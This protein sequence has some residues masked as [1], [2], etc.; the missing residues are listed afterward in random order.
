MNTI[1]KDDPSPLFDGLLFEKINP[2]IEKAISF[3]FR[4]IDFDTESLL[5]LKKHSDGNVVYA[6]FHTSNLSL[7]LLHSLLKR[8]GLKTPKFALEYNPFMLQRSITS[9]SGFSG[10]STTSSPATK[11]TMSSTPAISS[12]CCR[13]RKASSFRLFRS[14][15]F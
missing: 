10:R 1:R 15:I 4:K 9:S 11:E 5:T 6:S 2:L 3:F 12:G 14:G 8:H 13:Q 7:L